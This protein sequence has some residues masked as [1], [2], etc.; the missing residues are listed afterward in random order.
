MKL[1]RFKIIQASFDSTTGISTTIL[2]TDL[3]RFIGTAK[4]HPDDES[5]ASKY[6]GCRYAEMRATIKYLKMKK[7][8]IKQQIK[9]LSNI[10]PHIK[11]NK[12]KII[13]NNSIKEWEEFEADCVFRIEQLS[14]SLQKSIEERDK[15]LNKI[16]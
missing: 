8:V 6:A 12:D 9:T 3:G 11:G 5:T 13:I 15:I 10:Y 2:E 7:K 4:L 1:Y 16:K 14:N